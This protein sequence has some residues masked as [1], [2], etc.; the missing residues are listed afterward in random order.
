MYEWKE[1]ENL[2]EILVKEKIRAR[3]NRPEFYLKPET[4]YYKEF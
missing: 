1:E 4:L 2:V 3:K